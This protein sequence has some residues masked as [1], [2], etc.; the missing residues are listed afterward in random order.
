MTF[1]A[2][3]IH[4]CCLSWIAS[5][6]DNS[7]GFVASHYSL[8]MYPISICSQSVSCAVRDKILDFSTFSLE[9]YEY[10][11]RPDKGF[12]SVIIPNKLLAFASP[13]DCGHFPDGGF[14][15]KPCMYTL[16]VL[17]DCSYFYSVIISPFLLARVCVCVCMFMCVYVC[18]CVFVSQCCFFS[19]PTFARYSPNST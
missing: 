18:M 19:Q 11:Q 9:S 16:I 8:L 13:Y 7:F 4:I 10:Y 2:C 17:A 14:A 1:R 3:R 12:I 15:F 6:Y 5:K